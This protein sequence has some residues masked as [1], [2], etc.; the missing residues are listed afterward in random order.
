[1]LPMNRSQQ[2]I[3]NVENILS[4]YRNRIRNEKQLVLLYWQLIDGVEMDK[5]VISTPCFLEKATPYSDIIN[6]KILIESKRG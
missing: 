3:S 6:T 5:Q 4:K 2:L 1:M